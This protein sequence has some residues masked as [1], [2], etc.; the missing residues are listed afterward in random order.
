MVP[1]AI[2]VCS[3]M[4]RPSSA[5]AGTGLAEAMAARKTPMATI[6]LVSI[7]GVVLLTG[8]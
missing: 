7:L 2:S 6:C 5:R 1:S 4:T 3:M 8:C